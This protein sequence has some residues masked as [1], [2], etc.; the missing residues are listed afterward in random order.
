MYDE[1]VLESWL[2]GLSHVDSVGWKG[3]GEDSGR[4]YG[5]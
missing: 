3:D 1:S 5:F 4:T 2:V